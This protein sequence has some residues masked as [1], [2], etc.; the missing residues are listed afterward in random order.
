MNRPR[1]APLGAIIVIVVLVAGGLLLF[2][3]SEAPPSPS[4]QVCG[5]PDPIRRYL[6]AGWTERSPS[7]LLLVPRPYLHIVPDDGEAITS[8]WPPFQRVPLAFYAPGMIAPSGEIS[9][10]ASLADVM[11]TTVTFLRGA[12][13]GDGTS[14]EEVASFE[15]LI[16]DP[17]LKVVVTVTWSGAGW[18]VLGLWPGDQENL[19]RVTRRGIGLRDAVVGFAP[20]GPAAVAATLATGGVPSTHGIRRGNE[21]LRVRSLA[22]RWALQTERRAKV[23]AFGSTSAGSMVLGAEG[24][25]VETSADSPREV[26]ESVENAIVK[27]GFGDDDV[28]DLIYIAH[29]DVRRAVREAGPGTEEVFRAV[30]AV[31]DALGRIVELLDAEVG[32]GRYLVVVAGDGGSPPVDGSYPLTAASLRRA[33]ESEFEVEVERVSGLGLSIEPDDPR[34]D[35][36]T[37]RMAERLIEMNV[38]DLVEDVPREISERKAFE[39][40]VSATDFERIDCAAEPTSGHG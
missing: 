13:R 1:C 3:P 8:P 32:Q 15:D 28:A 14:L 18:E 2:R 29:D 6:E 16:D 23:A 25:R 40:S 4:S 22:D 17:P 11:P 26:A 5:A 38:E 21:T 27:D 37:R 19:L 36:L 30:E 12:I 10:D 33:L 31:D 34:T 39:L 7:E 9:G 35:E 24:A 20:A